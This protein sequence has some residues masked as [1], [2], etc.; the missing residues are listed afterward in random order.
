MLFMTVSGT[1]KKWWFKKKKNP[2]NQT[3]IQKMNMIP[4]IML[5]VKINSKQ[6]K[7]EQKTKKY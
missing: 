7:K 2:R 1:V 3:S 6:L 5:K 4:S